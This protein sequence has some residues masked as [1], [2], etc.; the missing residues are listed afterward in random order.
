MSR[1]SKDRSPAAVPATR[2]PARTEAD[3]ASTEVPAGTQKSASFE[4]VP[5]A[6]SID[7]PAAA[8]RRLKDAAPTLKA[9]VASLDAHATAASQLKRWNSE[10]KRG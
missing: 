6:P 3:A 1:I 5:G 7:A 9:S 4:P 2:L 8:F 10:L